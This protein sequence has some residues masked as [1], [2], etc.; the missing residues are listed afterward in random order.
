MKCK[1]VGTGAHPRWAKE[2]KKRGECLW[3]GEGKG[4]EPP[5]VCRRTPP[6]TIPA[7]S[8]EEGIT[9]WVLPCPSQ[10]CYRQGQEMPQELPGI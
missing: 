7:S 6:Q 9:S 10:P 4:E 5:T 2:P 3:K 1:Y 8:L